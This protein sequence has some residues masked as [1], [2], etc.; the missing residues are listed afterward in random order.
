M[1]KESSSLK[2]SLLRM[3]SCACHMDKSNYQSACSSMGHRTVNVPGGHQRVARSESSGKDT[4]ELN[5]IDTL[6]LFISVHVLL[7]VL[8]V[9]TNKSSSHLRVVLWC[10]G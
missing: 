5:K 10:N 1:K 8:H 3:M 4:V 7:H 2:N 6:K 9:K